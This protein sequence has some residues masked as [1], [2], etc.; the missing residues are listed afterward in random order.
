MTMSQDPIFQIQMTVRTL[1]DCFNKKERQ[2]FFKMPCG[3]CGVKEN[4]GANKN[5][6]EILILKFKY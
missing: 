5:E 2:A 3:I 1:R 6:V 4:N